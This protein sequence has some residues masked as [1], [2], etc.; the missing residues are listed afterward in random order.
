[1]K[2]YLGQVPAML[3]Q[4]K[5]LTEDNL[6]SAFKEDEKSTVTDGRYPF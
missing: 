3:V 1:M 5:P 2:D 6:S 4:M